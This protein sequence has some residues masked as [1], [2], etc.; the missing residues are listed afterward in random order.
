MS[1]FRFRGFRYAGLVF[2]LWLMPRVSQAHEFAPH[3]VTLE[4]EVPGRY[5]LWTR[6]AEGAPPPNIV[7]S[8]GCRIGVAQLVCH[9]SRPSLR[10]EGLAPEGAGL[11]VRVAE[12]DGRITEHFVTADAPEVTLSPETGEAHPILQYVFLGAE[13]VWVGVDHLLFLW[14]L[15]ILL[16][17]RRRLALSVSA[18]TVG[19]S[20]TLALALL[21]WAP[22]QPPI[23][24]AIAWS[25]V[26]LARA[27]VLRRQADVGPHYGMSVF[28]GLI[29]GFGLAGALSEIGLPAG[30]RVASLLAFNV[31]VEFG[32]LVFIGLV[33]VALQVI[34]PKIMTPWA[35]Y[36]AGV[37]GCTWLFVRVAALG[38]GG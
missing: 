20:V 5:A 8:P 28:F 35:G 12:I 37:L 16:P 13:H 7:T 32:Q 26:L 36:A 29:H 19:H 34:R 33:S 1:A 25:I 3:V 4:A 17:D 15:T 30:E 22:P 38:T 31:G 18:F 2:V 9:E 11:W 23:E 21:A 14:M 24:A 27:V 10:F 6:W